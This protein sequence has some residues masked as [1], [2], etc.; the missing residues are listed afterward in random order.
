MQFIERFAGWLE[1][2]NLG[3]RK[4]PNAQKTRLEWY[5]MLEEFRKY[6]FDILERLTNFQQ[7]DTG[8]SGQR[9]FSR[10]VR[11]SRL[12]FLTHRPDPIRNRLG[13]FGNDQ[14]GFHDL[15]PS[16][17][18]QRTEHRLNLISGPVE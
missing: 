18:L 12:E 8:R 4:I 11:N 6:S 1:K 10:H 13:Q 5:A 15:H 17:I 7:P 2:E 3:V 16:L 14:T 9:D